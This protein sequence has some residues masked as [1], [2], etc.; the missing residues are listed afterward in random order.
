MKSA[1]KRVFSLMLVAMLLVTAIPFQASAATGGTVTVVLKQGKTEVDTQEI[2]VKELPTTVNKLFKYG[3]IDTS[4][5]E[6]DLTKIAIFGGDTIDGE[7]ELNDGDLVYIRYEKKAEETEPKETEPKETQPENKSITLKLLFNDDTNVSKTITREPKNGS[8]TIADLLTY[9]YDANWSDNYDFY[10]ANNDRIGTVYEKDTVIKAGEYVNVRLTSKKQDEEVKPISI[11]VKVNNSDNVV[12]E[13]S[14]VPANGEYALVSNLLSYCWNGDWDNAYTFDHAWSHEQGKNVAKN[15]KIYAGDTVYI[16]VNRGADGD[17]DVATDTVKVKFYFNDKT[18]SSGS[19]TYT[20]K[21]GKSVSIKTILNSWKKDWDDDYD[22]VRADITV[23]GTTK[24]T[25]NVNS[26]LMPGQTINIRL[27]NEGFSGTTD[28][29]EKTAKDVYLYIHDWDNYSSSKNI[30]KVKLNDWTCVK[31]YGEVDMSDVHTIVNTY[32]TN[33][34]GGKIPVSDMD[35]IYLT[36]RDT[37]INRIEDENKYDSIDN[38]KEMRMENVVVMHVWIRNYKAKSTTSS[39]TN[40][41]T[42]DSVMMTVTTLGVT[43]SALAAAYY[44]SKKRMAR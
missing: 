5:V 25:T 42:G 10:R 34:S 22:F 17:E 4:A 1:L 36:N 7:T 26:T 20:G 8:A 2:T 9:W 35:G 44:V 39:S 23:D 3:K 43:A 19:Y 18:T 32:Y 31:V 6:G 27:W 41:K 13:G 37:E 21:A 11:V 24:K 14:K 38:V 16:M 12:W 29:N 40:P 33:K 28:Y 30:K 15:G